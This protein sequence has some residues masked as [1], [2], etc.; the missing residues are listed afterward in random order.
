MAEEED[1]Q[2]VVNAA[3]AL[4]ALAEELDAYKG[5]GRWSFTGLDEFS[6]RQ[7]SA[8]KELQAAIRDLDAKEKR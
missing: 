8:Y 3:R 4:L 6:M 2:R 5:S 7:G 1:S